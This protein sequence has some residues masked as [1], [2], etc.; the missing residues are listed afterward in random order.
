MGET[1]FVINLKVVVLS[2]LCNIYVPFSVLEFVV[3]VEGVAP[4]KGRGSC[5]NRKVYALGKSIC[6]NQKG[7][8][9]GNKVKM[10]ILWLCQL[11]RVFYICKTVF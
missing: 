11:K 4:T 5:N 9:Q 10:I 1:N 8:K 7:V 6:N 2:L 3:T